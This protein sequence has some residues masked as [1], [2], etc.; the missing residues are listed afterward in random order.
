V[1]RPLSRVRFADGGV[2]RVLSRRADSW[3]LRTKPRTA[4]SLVRFSVI[5]SNTAFCTDRT[6]VDAMLALPERELTI[7]YTLLCAIA[8]DATDEQTIL[9]SQVVFVVKQTGP[10]G[11]AEPG[12][13]VR[14]WGLRVV[15]GGPQLALR[16]NDI[17][18]ARQVHPA[19]VA[20]LAG[21]PDSMPKPHV[22]VNGFSQLRLSLAEGGVDVEARAVMQRRDSGLS[23]WVPT[24]PRVAAT[25]MTSALLSLA[26]G[27]RAQLVS[28]ASISARR[29]LTAP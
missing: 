13:F 17:A 14:P 11:R 19:E 2:V 6:E 10:Y 12:V 24:L 21:T 29:Y 7:C 3:L 5:G 20:A 23:H 15:H 9:A 25:N 8:S 16:A 28:Q 4:N 26:L 27:V 22:P 1:S 18:V